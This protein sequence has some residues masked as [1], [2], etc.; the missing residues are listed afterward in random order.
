M[1]VRLRGRRYVRYVLLLVALAAVVVIAAQ[2]ISKRSAA[3]EAAQPAAVTP[4]RPAPQV[5][6]MVVDRTR[7]VEQATFPGEVRASATADVIS[8]VAG[9]LGAV[10]VDEGSFVG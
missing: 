5:R 9:R 10:L 4:T 7:L 3:K 8:R 1:T 2:W 6:T